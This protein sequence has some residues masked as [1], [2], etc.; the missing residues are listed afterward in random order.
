MTIFKFRASKD[1]THRVKKQLT[2]WDKIFAIHIYA[3]RLIL[4]ICKEF[5]KQPQKPVQPH[6][7]MGK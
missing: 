5:L 2:E 1:T 7:K 4:R 3:K 6:S